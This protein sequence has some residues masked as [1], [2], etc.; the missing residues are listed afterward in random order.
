MLRMVYVITYAGYSVLWCS[1]LQAEIALITTEAEYIVLSQVM[2]DVILFMVM[3]KEVS[4]IFDI[5]IP[6]PEVFVK[7]SSITKGVLASRNRFFQQEQNILLLSITI[8][9]VLCKRKL[10]RYVILIQE[11]K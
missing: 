8:Y 2:R 7:S 4:F 11:N 1:K 9:E 3:V 10:F 5:H 6:K